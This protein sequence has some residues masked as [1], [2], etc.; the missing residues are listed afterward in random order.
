[1]K[2]VLKK[3]KRT[4]KFA[5][6][7][8]FIISIGYIVS[9]TFFTKSIIELTGIE[10]FIRFT[11]LILC[12]AYF[13]AYLYIGLSKLVARKYFLFYLLSIVSIFFIIVFS[14]SSYFIDLI[15]SKISGFNEKDKI[16][17]TS[18]LISMN[19]TTLNN[20]SVIG[21]IDDD[22]SIEG[23]ILAKEIIKKNNLSQK[24]KKFN[25]DEDDA[26][27]TM[28]YALYAHEIDAIFISS[29]YVTLYSGEEDFGNIANET[30]VLYKE[31][32]EYANQDSHITSNKL[33]T[34]PFSV[35]VLGVDSEYDGL[36]AN[37]AFNGDTLILATFNPK[38]FSAT[39]LSIP[40]DTYVPIACRK[41]AYAKIN[42]SAAYGTSCVIDTIE[43][44]TDIKID[45]YAKINFKGVVDLVEVVNGVTVDVQEPD[46]IYNH[47]F[48]CG[49]KVCEQN[50]DRLWGDKT[51]YINPG[52]QT[53]NGEQ[54]LAYARCRGL[55]ADSD[56]ARNRHQ[57]DIIM[58]LAK[59]MIKID[60]Y[61]TFK[62]ILDAISN[63]IATNMS[64]NQ[65]LSSYK[66]FKDM[67]G[68]ALKDQ[69]FVNIQKSRLETYNLP[70]YIPASGRISAALGY[71][72]ASLDDIVKTMKIDLELEKPE[73]IKTF[74]YSLN[75]T[76]EARVAGA[77]LRSGASNSI[78]QSYIGKSR[79]AAEEYCSDNNLKCTFTYIDN[80]SNYYD[81]S[82]ASDLIAAQNPHEGT[83]MKDV[84]NITFYING[85]IT[86][87]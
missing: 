85:V 66:V 64:T 51:V 61:N 58:A 41:N 1:M 29:N 39:L 76:Y 27:L 80:N 53:L 3:L 43:Q 9:Y 59:K 49:G 26:Y 18:Y 4:N 16:L 42:S 28:L 10:T 84:S 21:M 17:Y 30:K 50:S 56:L 81:E 65:V 14:F 67:I 70:V 2:K 37:A 73:L 44:L 31:S 69:E 36:N 8:Y 24:V 46:Y 75:E 74:S 38:T 68:K 6:F 34:E 20:S 82:I 52:I 11:V 33:L 79:S 7:L 83:L 22:K 23:N 13:F 54:A 48:N 63:N 32:K 15:F 62:K 87:N 47:G 12:L 77:N 57:Q 78:L 72:E 40:R 5:K 45:Y 19:D 55:Y 86:E 71:Y 25:K 35:L 60:N